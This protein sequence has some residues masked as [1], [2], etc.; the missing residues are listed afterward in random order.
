MNLLALAEEH[1][2][3][4][5][6]WLWLDRRKEV[7]GFMLK[8]LEPGEHCLRVKEKNSKAKRQADRLNPEP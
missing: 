4:R 7:H 8:V 5:V 6:I 1:H 3:S 2:G